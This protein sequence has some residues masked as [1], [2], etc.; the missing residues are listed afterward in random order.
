V[1]F[2]FDLQEI[3]PEKRDGADSAV[4]AP[5]DDDERLPN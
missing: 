5:E 1:R 3:A 2:L 4:R